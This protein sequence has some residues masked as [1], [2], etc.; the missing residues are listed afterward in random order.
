MK[1][2][3]IEDGG[4]DAGLVMLEAIYPDGAELSLREIAEICGCRWQ[5]IWYIEKQALKKMKKE[6][7][8][9][10]IFSQEIL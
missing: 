8:A 2:E 1:F 3:E 7:E 10:R 6:L 5:N 9:R 4:I